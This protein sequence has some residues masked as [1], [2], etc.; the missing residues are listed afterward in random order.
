MAK[1]LKTVPQKEKASSSRPSGDKAPVEP[2]IHDYVPGP[3]TLKI[4]FKVDNPSSVPGIT[5]DAA[6]RP[7]SGEEEAKSPVLKPG[8]EKKRR[9][10]PRLEDPKPKTR[11][12]RRKEI[13]LP[14]DSVQRLREEEEE[15]DNASALVIRSAKAIEVARAPEPMAAVPVDVS[16]EIPSLDRSTLSDLLG[17]MTVGHSPFLLT[18]SKE[19][20]KEVRELKTPD[21][22]RGSSVGDPFRDC[23]TRVDD[24]SDIGDTSL[25]Q[26]EAQRFITRAISRFCVDLSQCEAELQKVSGERDA[27][28]LLC[29]Q[30]DKVIKDLQADLSKQKV[31]KIELLREEVDQIKAESKR[32]EELE[33]RLAEAKAEVESSKIMADKSIAVYRADAEA[34]QM[35]AREAAD[36]VDAQA[37]W[38]AELA[39]CRSRR[40]TLEEI[41]VRGFGLTEEIKKAKELEAEAEALASDDDDD[42]CSKS[43]SEDGEEPDREA[44]TPDDD[45]EA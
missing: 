18:F 35:E 5:K 8:K 44:N 37:H 12:V 41:H 9:A 24:A 25:L 33:T 13:S 32:I 45:Q 31:E 38:V 16:P 29:S 6:L 39:K 20:L 40:E 4:D 42:G 2:S 11:R 26:E 22:G 19:A 21:M 34:A 15:E 27:L 17:D 1:T 3:C 28:R 36:T 30:K 7:S 23:F 14:I 10:T 43:G